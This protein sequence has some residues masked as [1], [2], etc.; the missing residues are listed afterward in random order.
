MITE[1]QKST[2]AIFTNKHNEKKL[3]YYPCPKN[4]NTS[5]KLFFV[6]HLGIENKFKFIG[7]KVPSFKQTKKDLNG[8]KNLVNFLPNYQPFCKIDIDIKCCF[9]RNPF[10]RFVSTYRNRVIY[11]NDIQFRNHSMDMI[12]DK[13]ENGLFEN[14]HFLPQ[15]FFLGNDLEYYTF[16]ADVNN[17]IIFEDEVNKFFGKKIKFPKLQTRGKETK[18]KLNNAQLDIIRKIYAKDFE[19]YSTKL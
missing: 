18:I 14:K 19:L 7:D 17:T 4:A 5:A 6:K 3:A 10:E 13:L 1:I 2:Y 12:L 15:N 11:H 8:K 16:Y 9:V